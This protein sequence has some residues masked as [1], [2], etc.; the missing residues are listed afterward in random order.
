MHKISILGPALTFWLIAQPLI[1]A[2]AQVKIGNNVGSI[3]ETSLLELESTTRTL[4]LTRVD[5]D[6]MSVL[7]PL[8]GALVY[9]TDES[10]IFFYQGGLWQNMCSEN[11]GLAFE[12]NEDGTL[13]LHTETGSLSLDGRPETLTRFIDNENGSYTYIDE[14]GDETLLNTGTGDSMH[15]GT[16]GSVF[17]ANTTDGS[18]DEANADFFWDDTNKRLGI[19]TNTPSNELVVEGITRSSRISSSFG[20]AA[21][22]SYHFTGS[23]NSGM[24]A[25]SFGEMAL[26]SSGQEVVRVTGGDRVGIRVTNPQATLHVGGDLIVEGTI[27]T[28]T[29][30]KSAQTTSNPSAIRRL[31]ETKA[32][33]KLS[34][35]T[36]ILEAGVEQLF[37]PSPGTNEGLILVIKD[38]GSQPTLL[39]LPYIN[40]QS[41][42]ATVTLPKGTLWLQSDGV[43]WQQIN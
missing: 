36:L 9:N 37:L 34:D 13:T 26:A 17:F 3:D 30:A 43:D 6:Q 31:S 40:L 32:V 5:N 20:T 18:P 7:Q 11:S 21:F 35:H 23:F 28:G 25:P 12:E 29:T 41:E 22:P 2:R 33:A 1:F 15:V 39:N 10:C 4:V 38:L 42:A 24:F 19:G 8:A 14:N 27:I 16:P